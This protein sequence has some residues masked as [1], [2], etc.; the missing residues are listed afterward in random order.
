M[1]IVHPVIVEN[2]KSYFSQKNIKTC[3]LDSKYMQQNGHK[4]LILWIDLQGF[5]YSRLHSTKSHNLRTFFLLFINTWDIIDLTFNYWRQLQLLVWRYVCVM[6]VF[7]RVACTWLSHTLLAA[8]HRPMEITMSSLQIE[9][10]YLF[11]KFSSLGNVYLFFILKSSLMFPWYRS[12]IAFDRGR[13]LYLKLPHYCL[14][15][16]GN[17]TLDL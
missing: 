10:V 14:D 7:V 5:C 13:L 15:I 6:D 1:E 11:S 16:I 12:G 9:L 3:I 2:Q 4:M 8:L 17:F